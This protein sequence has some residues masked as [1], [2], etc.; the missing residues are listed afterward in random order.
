MKKFHTRK[1]NKFIAF[2]VLV[3]CLEKDCCLNGSINATGLINFFC[4]F[5]S[6]SIWLFA[7]VIIIIVGVSFS[8]KRG[9]HDSVY[10]FWVGKGMSLGGWVSFTTWENVRWVEQQ[11]RH[12]WR[13]SSFLFHIRFLFLLT[14]SV[15]WNKRSCS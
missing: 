15:S 8:L 6:L 1:M 13:G 11:L 9:L 14:V 10:L 12:V 4:L 7:R 3:G 5:F 2:P